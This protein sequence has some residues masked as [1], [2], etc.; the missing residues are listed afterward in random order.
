MEVVKSSTQKLGN[1]GTKLGCGPLI[2]ALCT[3]WN[4]LWLPDHIRFCSAGPLQCSMPRMGGAPLMLTLI[5]KF[6]KLF[7]VQCNH[8]VCLHLSRMVWREVNCPCSLSV[9]LIWDYKGGRCLEVC[10]RNTLSVL[11]HAKR[12]VWKR[13]Q[14]LCSSL[15]LQSRKP[16]QAW[17]HWEVL[18]ILK[19][20]CPLLLPCGNGTEWLCMS[21]G[22]W[23]MQYRTW[24]LKPVSWQ[25]QQM[26]RELSERPE[27]RGFE[28][29]S[30]GTSVLLGIQLGFA[31]M[32]CWRLMC[33]LGNVSGT[34]PP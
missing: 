5:N 7:H 19:Q 29:G 11:V 18:I 4:D 26:S 21:C 1:D 13:A 15:C 6:K 16:Y 20:F 28:S 24:T 27:Q 22:C 12:L 3:F 10:S 34:Q 23:G 31:C 25:Q 2:Q 32:V 14:G 9:L 33:V 8:E 17:M 30:W